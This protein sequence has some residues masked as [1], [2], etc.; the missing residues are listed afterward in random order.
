KV[1]ASTYFACLEAGTPVNTCRA[2]YLNFVP[3][4]R[5]EAVWKEDWDLI[6]TGGGRSVLF[7]TPAFQ[8]GISQSILQGSRG[9]P[10]LAWNAA[11][12][13][14]VLVFTSFPGVRVGWHTVGGTSASSPQLAA[15]IALANQMRAQAGKGPVGHLNPRLYQL[16]ASDFT[17][18]V[19]LTFGTGAGMTTQIGRASCR[20]RVCISV[21]GW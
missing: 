14:G 20:E 9:I 10:D 11:V 17:D 2:S 5:T 4:G 8:S 6:A 18:I 3:G 12:N 21:G 19:P 15:L 7:A 13:G 16:P 1:Q